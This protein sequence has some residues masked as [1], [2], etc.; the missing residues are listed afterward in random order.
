LP[1]KL[2]TVKL[3]LKAG[4]LQRCNCRAKQCP[5]QCIIGHLTNHPCGE[6][7]VKT[8]LLQGHIGSN[9]ACGG[10]YGLWDGFAYG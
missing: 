9:S 4:L 10:L 3:S 2:A 7:T 5:G 6:I 8:C 1:L